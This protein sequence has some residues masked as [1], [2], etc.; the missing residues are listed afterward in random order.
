VNP[1]RYDPDQWAFMNL[2][3]TQEKIQRDLRSAIVR[4]LDT[5]PEKALLFRASAV[6]GI[7]RY[8]FEEFLTRE[9]G[10][11]YEKATAEE[12]LIA[13]SVA[14]RRMRTDEE[15]EKWLAEIMA[16]HP[17]MTDEEL[18]GK[19]KQFEELEARLKAE[20]KEHWWD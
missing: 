3:E 14:R 4:F 17:R 15:V 5:A 9:D 12:V 20:G 6:L 18:D 8:Y 10:D 13:L 2:P 11:D 19:V 7:L 1:D 16:A